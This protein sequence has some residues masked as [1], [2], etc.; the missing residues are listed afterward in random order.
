MLG[1]DWLGS[2]M[3]QAYFRRI[4]MASLEHNI[5]IFPHQF[6]PTGSFLARG[7]FS[8]RSFWIMPTW[9]LFHLPRSQNQKSFLWPFF[10]P[11]P[12]GNACYA[13][14]KFSFFGTLSPTSLCFCCPSV[15]AFNGVQLYHF[16]C[17]PNLNHS[18]E[19]LV[20]YV[21]SRK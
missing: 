21:G 19:S 20:Y 10:A 6:A 14:Y 11:K 12:N 18:G 4:H 7:H 8:F 2:F 15:G 16:E 9:L 13:G 17:K 1:L 5:A 3:I